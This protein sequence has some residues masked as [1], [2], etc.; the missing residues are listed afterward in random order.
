MIATGRQLDYVSLTDGALLEI[1]QPLLKA[2]WVQDMLAHWNLHEC[3]LLFEIL[4]AEA[5]L[6]LVSHEG[7]LM[8]RAR[9]FDRHSAVLDAVH[10]SEVDT[11]YSLGL[12]IKYLII[13]IELAIAAHTTVPP[14]VVWCTA[15]LAL[16]K[17]KADDFD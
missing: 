3:L 2:V 10:D 12:R 14:A 15:M 4:Q 11:N 9:L 7:Q 5:T 16:S 13:F 1:Y 8:P 17:E 6:L